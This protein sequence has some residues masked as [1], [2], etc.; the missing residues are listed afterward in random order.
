MTEVKTPADDN[1][2]LDNSTGTDAA[3]PD[4]G[5]P[6]SVR[7]ETKILAASLLEKFAVEKISPKQMCELE[8]F[9]G[10]LDLKGNPENNPEV[11]KS[12]AARLEAIGCKRKDI[13]EKSLVLA[14]ETDK[15]SADI[16]SLVT[17]AKEPTE[18]Y[19]SNVGVYHFTVG[20]VGGKVLA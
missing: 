19:R 2:Q 20:E 4:T 5:K 14:N 18:N 10:G 17:S 16:N 15:A 7:E 11:L 6:K 3:V 1:G 12:I 13:H 8:G 9:I